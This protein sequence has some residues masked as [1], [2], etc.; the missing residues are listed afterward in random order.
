MTPSLKGSASPDMALV[1]RSPA[2]SSSHLPSRPCPSLGLLLTSKSFL[3]KARK[4]AREHSQPQHQLHGPASHAQAQPRACLSHLCT[5]HR[6]ATGRPRLRSAWGFVPEASLGTC[7]FSAYP[8]QTGQT[9]SASEL[10]EVQTAQCLSSEEKLFPQMPSPLSWGVG[11]VPNPVTLGKERLL[12]FPAALASEEILPKHHIP[13]RVRIFGTG[14]QG[15][16]E[17][18]KSQENQKNHTGGERGFACTLKSTVVTDLKEILTKVMGL[19]EKTITRGLG[20][21]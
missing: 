15:K 13:P 1:P 4:A 7:F 10:W 12:T 20:P 19:E 14:P 2:G 17:S 5:H 21:H 6:W 8:S 18:Q 9:P 11:S 16:S 3:R